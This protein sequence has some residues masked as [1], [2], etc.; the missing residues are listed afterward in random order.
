MRVFHPCPALTVHAEMKR[1]RESRR[2]ARSL[3]K[4]LPGRVHSLILSLWHSSLNLVNLL[5]GQ[6][7]TQAKTL[8][9]RKEARR[10]YTCTP[11]PREQVEN[12]ILV[13][14]V[15]LRTSQEYWPTL[16]RILEFEVV[17]FFIH[18]LRL[19]LPPLVHDVIELVVME[20]DLV[21]RDCRALDDHAV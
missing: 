1:K 9:N 15:A 5:L 3:S 14:P 18:L 12:R 11:L 6:T 7:V 2:V 21:S 16:S 20:I 8:H 10:R 17:I 4:Q 19:L 13:V